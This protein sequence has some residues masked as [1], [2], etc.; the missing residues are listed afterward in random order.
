MWNSSWN[1][2]QKI[3]LNSNMLGGGNKSILFLLQ[4]GCRHREVTHWCFDS[5]YWSFSVIYDHFISYTFL[6]TIFFQAEV[7]PCTR[8]F[9]F[10][11]L[12]FSPIETECLINKKHLFYL[13]QRFNKV[14]PSN[15][16][17]YLGKK[18]SCS[19][20]L[21]RSIGMGVA[22]TW[23]INLI[24]VQL[25]V[26]Y[27]T[28]LCFVQLSARRVTSGLHPYLCLPQLYSSDSPALS[29]KAEALI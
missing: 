3:R 20:A 22:E 14:Q 12:T 27:A 6:I 1:I 24:S 21:K 2:S 13:W 15:F 4:D 18:K 11:Y 26:T 19:S 7:P 23:V 10:I 28:D 8:G 29:L 17:P 5:T 16:G 25:C 9:I